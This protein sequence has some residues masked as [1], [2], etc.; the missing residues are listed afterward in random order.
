MDAGACG[1]YGWVAGRGGGISQ[2][3]DLNYGIL[4]YA[5]QLVYSNSPN[6]YHKK[7]YGGQ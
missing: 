7:N 3:P 1:T 4:I 6:Q 5:R 2:A